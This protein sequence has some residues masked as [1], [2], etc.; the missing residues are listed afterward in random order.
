MKHRNLQQSLSTR[1]FLTLATLI[2]PAFA[3]EELSEEFLEYIADYENVDGDLVDP[4][5][6]AEDLETL[7]QQSAQQL[8]QNTEQ[9]NTEQLNTEQRQDIDALDTEGE[10]AHE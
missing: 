2:T 6:F 10:Q 4:I 5:D 8:Q 7:A 1:L 3:A 9:L